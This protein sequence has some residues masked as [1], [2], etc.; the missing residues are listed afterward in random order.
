MYIDD[1]TWTD[2]NERIVVEPI[3][4]WEELSK[5]ALLKESPAKIKLA[6]RTKARKEALKDYAKT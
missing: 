2:E 5:K 3:K 1:R 6:A 4:I